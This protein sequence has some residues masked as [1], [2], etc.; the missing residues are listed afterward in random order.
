MKNDNT[1]AVCKPCCSNI[2]WES[3]KNNLKLRYPSLLD[4]DLTS[5]M[6]SGSLMFDALARKLG[7]SKDE[8]HI[9][10]LTS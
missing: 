3:K 1:A 8:L 5:S 6:A 4:E 9:V 10:I 2:N 7:L